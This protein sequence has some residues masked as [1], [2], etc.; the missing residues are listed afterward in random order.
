LVFGFWFCVFVLLFLLVSFSPPK[1][2][3]SF[4]F[5]FFALPKGKKNKEKGRGELNWVCAK[6][7]CV[8][9]N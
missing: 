6:Q 1:N 9:I 5:W 3:P 7:N 4:F 2:P 8:Q